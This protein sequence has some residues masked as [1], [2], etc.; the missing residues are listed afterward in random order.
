VGQA[1]KDAIHSFGN[2]ARGLHVF[3]HKASL[4][5]DEAR[6]NV[7]KL[8][9][10]KNPLN[11][12]FCSS[13]TE[14]LNLVIGGLIANC[15][16]VITTH[17]EHNS[18]LRP[19][20]LTGA[21]LLFLDCDEKGSVIVSSFDRIIKENTRFLVCTHGS[22]VTGNVVDIKALYSKCKE[23]N[24]TL[25][26][27]ICQTF[28]S[29]PVDLDM[30]DIFCFTGHKA[31]FGPQGVGGIITKTNHNFKIIKTGGAG[32]SSFEK[33]HSNKM[34]DVFEV[35]TLNTHSIAGL[36]EGLKFIFEMGLDNIIKKENLLLKT[37]YGEIQNLNRIKIYGNF[38]KN[39]PRLPIV[40]LNIDGL[41]ATELALKLA[42]KYNIATRASTHCAPLMHKFFGTTNQDFQGAVRFSFSYFNTI[43]EIE[44][45]VNA[46]KEIIKNAH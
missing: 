28:G 19:L 45:A 39:K 23:R 2:A 3:S 14:S 32:Y 35:G 21:E 4:A 44:T 30:A 46:L 11:V 1:V 15:D 7:S 27:D 24:I 6:N 22:N 34:P 42:N 9:N 33:L 5:I 13:G 17:L 25:I 40:T 43:D 10:L 31:L 29:I 16:S 37:F 20:Y 26:L 36:N 12:A 8:I 41:T 38:E 18:I